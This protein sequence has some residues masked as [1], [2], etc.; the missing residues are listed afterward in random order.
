MNYYYISLFHTLP[1]DIGSIDEEIIAHWEQ[2]KGTYTPWHVHQEIQNPQTPQ[3]EDQSTPVATPSDHPFGPMQM[4]EWKLI[5]HLHPGYNIE[6]DVPEIIG[7]RDF[8]ANENWSHTYIHLHL[9]EP[10]IFFFEFNQ[11]NIQS[12][13]H[14]SSNLPQDHTLSPTQKETFTIVLSH[15]KNPSPKPPLIIIIQGTTQTGKY[16]LIKCLQHAFIE[17]SSISINPLL[18][19][20][21]NDVASFNINSLTIHSIL[22]IHIQSMHHFEGKSLLHLQDHL[23]HVEYV[24]IDEK[25]FIGPKRLSCINNFLREVFPLH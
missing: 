18:L 8:N 13:L 25:S 7:Y 15:F 22:R 6:I 10:A 19:L 23:Y 17:K 21:P 11:S 9:Q 3:P 14:P 5:S 12:Q 24:L 2:K 20:A 1:N 16:H 4:N